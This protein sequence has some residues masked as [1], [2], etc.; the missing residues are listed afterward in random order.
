MRRVTIFGGTFD[1]IHFAHLLT[2]RDILEVTKADKIIFLPSFAPPHK[3][4]YASLDDRL[5]MVKLAIKDSPEFGC[6]EFEKTLAR[7]TYTINTLRKLKDE[8]D[9]VSISFIIGMDS[10]CEFASWKEPDALLREF[11]MLVIPRPGYERKDVSMRFQK[12]FRFVNARRIEISSTEI[13]ERVL[14]GKNIRYLTP[15]PV[16]DYIKGKGLYLESGKKG[17]E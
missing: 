5:H 7:P 15:V 8:L 14:K 12:K 3:D 2:G 17:E 16:V 13:R 9:F 4:V 6:S 1:P 11:E 10:A